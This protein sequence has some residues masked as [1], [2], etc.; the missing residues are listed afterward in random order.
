MRVWI[1]IAVAAAIAGLLSWGQAHSP[2]T[3]RRDKSGTAPQIGSSVDDLWRELEQKFEQRQYEEV[4]KIAEQARQA[5][6]NPLERVFL[7]HFRA[8]ALHRLR[9]QEPAQ[10]EELMRLWESLRQQ[11]RRIESTPYE[12]EATLALAFCYWQTDRA[13]AEQ[14]LSEALA[15]AAAPQTSPLALAQVLSFCAED[16]FEIKQWALCQQV[17][18]RTLALQEAHGADP[19]I[20]ARTH[21]NLGVLALKQNQFPIAQSHLQEALSIQEQQASDS[22]ALARTLKAM[23]ELAQRQNQTTEAQRYYQ[24]ALKMFSANTATDPEIAQVYLGLGELARQ[25][26]RWEDARKHYERALQLIAD[27]QAREAAQVQAGLGVVALERGELDSAWDHL[28]QAVQ[29]PRL[30]PLEKA[31]IEHELG[32]VAWRRGQTQD[33]ENYLKHVLEL[34]RQHGDTPLNIAKTLYNLGTLMLERGNLTEARELFTAVLEIRQREAPNSLAVAH[35]LIGIGFVAFYEQ[36]LVEARRLFA[37]ARTLYESLKA[38]AVDLSRAFMA[39]GLV[40]VEVGELEPAQALLEQARRLQ[41]ESQQKDTALYAQTLIGLGNLNLRRG[42][43]NQAFQNYFQAERIANQLAP[44]GFVRAQALV[45]LGNLALHQR[46]LQRAQSYYLQALEILQQQ[47][48]RA[49]LLV[50]VQ[51][52][53]GIV[54]LESGDYRYAEQ[55]FSKAQ[56]NATRLLGSDLAERVRLHSVV[57]QIRRGEEKQAFPDI[58]R[59]I[60]SLEAPGKNRLLRGQAYFYRGVVQM[61]QGL[62]HAARKDFEHALELYQK[63][64]PHTMFV[65]LTHLN[66]AKLDYR[67]GETN[68]ARGHLENALAII[69]QQYGSIID[70]DVQVA[71][72]ENYFEAYSL[73]AL[74][75]VAQGRYAR[76]VELL[77]Q[78]RA[79]SLR[80]QLQR[81]QQALLDA[82]PAWSAL[83]S[84]IQGAEAERLELQR[85]I[86]GLYA[87]AESGEKTPEEAERAARLL[88]AQLQELEQRLQQLDHALRTQFPNEARLVAPPR[89]SLAMIQQQLTPDEALLYHALVEKNLLILVVTRQEVHAHYRPVESFMA[90]RADIEDFISAVKEQGET[91]ALGARLYKTLIAPVADLLRGYRRVLLCP[92]GELSLLPW[93]A[94]VVERHNGKPVYWVERV[95]VHLT[96]SMG[97]Y[98]YARILTPSSQ[99]ALIAAV[100]NYE[101]ER[102]EQEARTPSTQVVQELSRRGGGLLSNLPA[103]AKEV[104]SI[105]RLIPSANVIREEAVQPDRLRELAAGVRILHF[106]CHAEA[107]S[108]NPLDSVLKFDAYNERQ[109]TAAQIMTQWRLQADLVLLSACETGTGKVYRYEG[110]YGL[111]RAFLH[112]GAKSVIATLWQVND[113]RTADLVTEFYKGYI[114]QKLPKDLALQQAQRRMLER[115]YEPYHWSGFVLIGDGQ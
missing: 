72:G 68:R 114:A 58:E 55:L 7:D 115:G 16:W 107:N 43:W 44:R 103:V 25:Q 98:R 112:A 102:A 3:N 109:L 18:E 78:S 23:G 85:R 13:R 11:Y 69:E 60:A 39:L 53:L 1:I 91:I 52:N 99:G 40:A 2:P 83:W 9:P 73:L 100:S 95:A 20:R 92:E 5:R 22:L 31:R 34:Q 77:E 42:A 28:Q 65:A 56:E 111:A 66:L 24:R 32:R 59:I 33:A 48:P 36:N 63:V 97:A 4:R 47:A 17:W 113:E 71:F 70:P 82:S 29:N 41:Q 35:A 81:N 54:A 37:D 61:R 106:A 79:R 94:L 90:L 64:A 105:Q 75:E 19:L 101:M 93:T 30:D 6:T 88:Y 104:D 26:Q 62:D 50:H 80:A 49:P 87:L 110:V 8:R 45:G 86:A 74:L 46:D 10:R 27:P 12:V 76:A 14:L 67:A 108:A 96:P 15:R 57:L 38:E 21:Y 89:L 84:Q 51:T